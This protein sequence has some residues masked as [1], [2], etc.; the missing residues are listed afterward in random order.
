MIR[1]LKKLGDDEKQLM[2]LRE[3]LQLAIKNDEAIAAARANAQKNIPIELSREDQRTLAEQI[4]DE[5]SQRV[6]AQSNLSQLFKG[7]EVLTILGLLNKDQIIGV[8]TLW[9]GIKDEL[10]RVNTKSLLPKDFV[11]FL[12]KYMD[13]AVSLQGALTVGLNSIEELEQIIPDAKTMDDLITFLMSRGKTD[14]LQQQAEALNKALPTYENFDTIARTP[15]IEQ[16][17]LIDEGSSL[18][19]NRILLDKAL[20][21]GNLGKVEK[22]LQFVTPANYKKMLDYLARLKVLEKSYRPA[23]PVPVRPV[24]VRPRTVTPTPPKSIAGVVKLKIPAEKDDA[25]AVRDFEEAVTDANKKYLDSIKPFHRSGIVKRR[26]DPN[27]TLRPDQEKSYNQFVD[28]NIKQVTDTLARYSEKERKAIETALR[29]SGWDVAPPD[30]YQFVGRGIKLGRG[31]PPSDKPK[32]AY[33]MKIGDGIKIE[34]KPVNIEFGKY[35]LNTNQLK[36]QV[37]HLKGRAGGALSWF[38]PT[39]MSDQ[40]TELI[41]EMIQSGSVNKHLLKSLDKD[42]Q[43]TFYEVCDKAGLLGVFKLTKPEDTTDKD[44]MAKFEILLGEYKAGSNSPLLIQQLRKH[45]IYFTNKG[46]IPKQKAL[47]ML[48]ELA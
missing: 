41:S 35:V 33:K 34:R 13:S 3:N 15:A 36:K 22:L 16:K 2:S 6:Q 17:D 11:L 20:A 5:D 7:Q 12:N 1:N 31:R 37:L 40:F 29:T 9:S 43:K 19:P 47:A 28:Y 18:Y 25:E 8:N 48:S 21:E 26:S 39:P 10:K 46:R 24:A 14:T 30:A 32:L 42:E 45:I 44:L 38:Q 23:R 27:Y 4:A